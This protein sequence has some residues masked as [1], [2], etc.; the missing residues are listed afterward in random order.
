MARVERSS[1]YFTCA[2]TRLVQALEEI[3]AERLR[4]TG[5]PDMGDLPEMSDVQQSWWSAQRKLRGKVE[6][7]LQEARQGRATVLDECVRRHM[8]PLPAQ[9]LLD[10]PVNE[11]I[12]Y[13]RA[14]TCAVLATALGVEAGEPVR[15]RQFSPSPEVTTARGSQTKT[16]AEKAFRA[17]TTSCDVGVGLPAAPLSGD[18]LPRLSVCSWN[19]R[20]SRELHIGATTLRDKVESL[21]TVLAAV[22]G[23]VALAVLQECPG[24]ALAARRVRVAPPAG[25]APN[26]GAPPAGLPPDD[27]EPPGADNEDADSLAGDDGQGFDEREHDE[28]TDRVDAGLPAAAEPMPALAPAPHDAAPAAAAEAEVPRAPS[29]DVL[30][31]APQMGDVVRARLEGWEYR[32][33]QTGA[34]AAGFAFNPRVL[35]IVHGPTPF[36]DPPRAGRVPFQRPPV[37]AVFVAAGDT[38]AAACAAPLGLIAVC[39]VHLKS[40]EGNHP[41]VQTQPEL[42]RLSDDVDDW[43]NSTLKDVA[44]ALPGCAALPLTKLIIGDFNLAYSEVGGPLNTNL[45]TAAGDAWRGLTDRGFRALVAEGTETNFAELVARGACYDNALLSCSGVPLCERT[46]GAIVQDVISNEL[47]DLERI[48]VAAEELR[49]LAPLASEFV[50][51][52]R[53]LFAEKFV[54]R[55]WSDHKPVMVTIQCKVPKAGDEEGGDGGGGAAAA[56]RH[57]RHL[58]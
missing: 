31:Q 47:D 37:L 53:Q 41:E 52:L 19:I 38:P 18:L 25:A 51:R 13:S 42:R 5:N 34:E 40:V 23:G 10:S 50:G 8:R 49:P 54:Y 45:A 14:D 20:A 7:L 3:E 16:K 30:Q 58:P 9:Q 1:G 46:T 24:R 21:A 15:L 39:S 28:E 12:S 17:L 27:M 56:V 43:I 36:G 26:N 11:V 29:G 6:Q 22:E 32:E 35:R 44:A 33:A 57:R 48:V 4:F 55:R 2:E